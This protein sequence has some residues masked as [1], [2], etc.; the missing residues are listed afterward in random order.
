MF[1]KFGKLKDLFLKHGILTHDFLKIASAP[2]VRID[3]CVSVDLCL[4]Q[5]FNIQL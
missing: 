3:A 1:L 4:S 2:R 5:C